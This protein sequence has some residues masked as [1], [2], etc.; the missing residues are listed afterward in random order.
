MLTPSDDLPDVAEVARIS[1]VCNAEMESMQYNVLNSIKTSTITFGDFE[2]LC[3]KA[4]VFFVWGVCGG[5]ALN[6]K[7]GNDKPL[8]MKAYSDILTKYVETGELPAGSDR[9][10]SSKRPVSLS[11]DVRLKEVARSFD[12]VK[13]Y[14]IKDLASIGIVEGETS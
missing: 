14:A 2:L 6:A 5:L 1:S 7:D 3:Y 11:R 8:N 13:R 9:S 10:K 4:G 12:I